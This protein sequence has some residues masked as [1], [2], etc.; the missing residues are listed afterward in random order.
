MRLA[1]SAS[2]GSDAGSCSRQF[3]RPR[4]ANHLVLRQRQQAADADPRIVLD[5]H[6]FGFRAREARIL[7][8]RRR[9]CEPARMQDSSDG[10][11]AVCLLCNEN[12][13][14]LRRVTA[15]ESSSVGSLCRQRAV[16]TQ[17]ARRDAES[18]KKPAS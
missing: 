14:R 13:R 12:V 18:E 1:S 17:L 8:A 16:Q 7:Q 2:Y 6:L 4:F 5:G 10:A 15:T 9:C 11:V 3:R